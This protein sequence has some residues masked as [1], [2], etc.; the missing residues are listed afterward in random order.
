LSDP[1]RLFLRFLRRLSD[2]LL[3]LLL[4]DDFRDLDLD[5][6][7]DLDFGLD[8]EVLRAR[9]VLRFV[10]FFRLGLRLFELDDLPM[11][12]NSV[13]AHNSHWRMRCWFKKHNPTWQRLG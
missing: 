11:A 7:G 12:E 1:F 5:F 2:L 10:F 6:D 9:L 13:S 4:S 3:L 8:S